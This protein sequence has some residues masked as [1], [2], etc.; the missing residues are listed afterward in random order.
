VIT[1]R[2]DTSLRQAVRRNVS[3]I[4]VPAG[5]VERLDERDYRV[6]TCRRPLAAGAVL[7]AIAVVIALPLG[8]ATGLSGRAE[9]GRG[10]TGVELQLASYH[11]RLPHGYHLSA[12]RSGPCVDEVQASAPVSPTPLRPA[13]SPLGAAQARIAQATSSA[14]GCVLMLLTPPFP[15]RSK[16]ADGDPNIPPGAREVTVGTYHAWLL[17]RAY[18]EPRS[19]DGKVAQE[20]GLVIESPAGEGQVRDLVIGCTGL[21]RGALVSLVATGLSSR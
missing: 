16:V 6:G 9:R 18:W 12:G 14:G 4:Q 8:L 5:L 11:L 2:F 15:L 7:A 3:D 17:P 1:E 21:S 19:A 20:N 13:S 10:A